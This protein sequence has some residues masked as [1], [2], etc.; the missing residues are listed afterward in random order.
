[1]LLSFAQFEREV[2]SER[3]RDKI[4]AS[5]KRGMWMGGV[6]PLGYDI[7]NKKLVINEAEAETVRH[8]FKRYVALGSV[9]VLRAEL[10]EAGIVSKR[11]VDRHGR[12]VG[13][14]PLARGALYLMLQNCLYRGEVAHK[15]ATLSR[16]TPSHDQSRSLGACSSQARGQSS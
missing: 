5:K 14:R 4:A 8:I 15:S 7:Q 3:I 6:V 13:G 12:I 11:R 2:A 16:A 1:M 10:T 9:D